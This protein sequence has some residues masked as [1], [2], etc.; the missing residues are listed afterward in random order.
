MNGDDLWHNLARGKRI[1]KL[2]ST[3]SVQTVNPD[4]RVF[5][6]PAWGTL[7]SFGFMLLPLLAGLGLF[8]YSVQH[9]VF[10]GMLLSGGYSLLMGGI[11]WMLLR[12]VRRNLSPDNWLARIGPTGILLKYRSYLHDDLPADDPVIL[13]LSWPQILETGLLEE[14]TTR[15]DADGSQRIRRRYLTISLDSDQVDTERIRA[16]LEFE[17]QRQPAGQRIG[18]LQHELFRARRNRAEN[19]EIRR[20]E[21]AVKREKELHP[22][23][24]NRMRFKSRPVVFLPPDRLQVE[25][26]QVTP[27]IRKLRQLLMDYTEFVEME[28]GLE[29][30]GEPLDDGV[31]ADRLAALLA[32]DETLAALRLVRNQFGCNVTAA[33]EYLRRSSQSELE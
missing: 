21:E 22:G 11:C 14:T 26:D 3:K 28:S 27:G 1:V 33:R 9:G 5:R 18:E 10:W 4:E 32:R 8:A 29:D 15:Q 16:A 17:H 7:F 6:I 23:A 25:W 24:R 12:A 13:A 20:L 2:L 19:D 30:N 31:F